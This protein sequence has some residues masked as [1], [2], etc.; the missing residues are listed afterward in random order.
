MTHRFGGHG[1]IGVSTKALG[2]SGPRPCP[3]STL[4]GSQRELRP[5]SFLA[6]VLQSRGRPLHQMRDGSIPGMASSQ[7]P[8][9]VR[10][11]TPGASPARSAGALREP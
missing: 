3:P 1:D 8:G 6:S 9:L 7:S 11:N 10:R 4:E 2:L 5:R